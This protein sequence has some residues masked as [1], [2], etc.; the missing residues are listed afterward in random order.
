MNFKRSSYKSNCGNNQEN[1]NEK[2][3]YMNKK[4]Y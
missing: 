4:N 2:E 3:G 1:I